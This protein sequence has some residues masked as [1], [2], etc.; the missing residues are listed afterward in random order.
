MPKS[1]RQTQEFRSARFA[2]FVLPFREG[3]RGLLFRLFTG[4]FDCADHVKRLFGHVVTRAFEDFFKAFDRVLNLYILALKTR[5][6]LSNRKRLR[7]ET[8]YLSRTV[9]G[10]LVVLAHFVEA[11]D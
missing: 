10:Q 6:L 9:D 8:L 11:A 2:F 3:R 5:E 4:L 1:Q 7:D